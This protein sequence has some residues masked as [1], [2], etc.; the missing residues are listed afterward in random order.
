MTLT[1]DRQK[2]LIEDVSLILKDLLKVIKVVSM[3]PEGN[4]LPQSMRRTFAEKLEDIVRNHGDITITVCRD[5]LALGSETV[6][7]DRF[8]EESLAGLFFETGFTNFTFKEGLDVEEIYKLLDA[9]KL[10][11]NSPGKSQDLVNL[12]WETGISRFA[13]TTIEDVALAE[14]DGD[15]IVQEHIGQSEPG[16]IGRSQMAAESIEN[17]SAIFDFNSARSEA[18]LE[19]SESSGGLHIPADQHDIYGIEPGQ[20]RQTVLDTGGIDA[21]ACR[22]TEAA[23]AMGLAD[24]Q[25]PATP[26]IADTNLILNDELKLSDEEGEQVRHIVREDAEFDLYESTAELVKELLHQE[27]EMN[28]FSEAVT[29]CEKVMNE[30][31]QAGKLA[32]A[33]QLL[34]YLAS[35]EGKIRE[36]K[37]LWAE[38]LKDARVTTGSRDR[39]KVLSGALNQHTDIGF[40]DLSRYLDQFGWE[41]L[42]GLTDMLGELEQ[43]K[44]REALCAFL[45]ERGKENTD[46]VSKGLFDKRW[47]VVRNSVVVI[48][49]VGGTKALAYLKKVVNHDDRR[50]RLAL[51]QS[52]S[53]CPDDDAVNLLR[54]AVRDRDPEIRKEAVN[55]I[56]ARRGQ[57][58]FDTITEIINDD[59]FG[60]LDPD[61]Q[62]AVL[63]AFSVLGGDQAVE[64]LTSLVARTNVFGS[65]NLAFYRN[66]AFQALSLNR[67]ERSEKALL[68]LASSWRSDIRKQAAEAMNR[69]RELIYGEQHVEYDN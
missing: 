53:N 51:V 1:N 32:Y 13:F 61:D 65:K 50:V 35:L 14:Y 63:N 57:I 37:P 58:A 46:L 5:H 67:S 19:E 2:Q 49:G 66:A 36:S 40:S 33:G 60:D 68:K 3:Y 18:Y 24:L 31:I 25:C 42:A 22:T 6:Y 54:Q 62:Q 47:Y 45:V 39:L 41:A 4:P 30:F 56:V 8:K 44:H 27:G 17:Y 23:E 34:A 38:R 59:S 64:Y 48:C 10:Y 69:R 11:V 15:F 29:V 21:T 16:N 26:V 28:G 52:L 9:L 55:S 12:I 7:T 43:Q 20:T